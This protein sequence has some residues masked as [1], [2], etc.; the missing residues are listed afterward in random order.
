[1][2][3][4]LSTAEVQPDD[5]A[6]RLARRER[7]LAEMEAADV[8]ILVVGREANARYVAGAPR[9]WLAGT[10]PFGPGAVLV[11]QTGSV[12]LMNTWDEGVPDDI[13]HEHLFGITFNALNFI[14]ALRDVD[15]AATARTV[16]TDAMNGGA[17]RMLSQSFPD[18]DLVDGEQLLQRA[19]RTKLPMEIDEIRAAVAVAE[20]ALEA[21]EAA[22]APGVTEQQLTGRFM[23]AMAAQGV[24]IPSTQDVAWI[25]SRQHPWHRTRRD[26]PI[27]PDDLVA[28]EAGVIRDGYIG[29]FGRTRVAGEANARAAELFRRRDDLCERLIAA[30]RPGAPLTGLLDA[31]DAAGVAAPPMPVARGLGLGYDTPVVTHALRQTASA[32]VFEPGMVLVLAAY[33]WQAGV[34]A[35]YGQEPVVITEGRPELLSSTPIVDR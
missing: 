24:T 4:P 29:E 32:E 19:R 26:T 18:A 23:E 9:L 3:P 2:K 22:L 33:V 15:G 10:R 8:D 34:G 11:R 1:M 12:Y 5:A 7:V 13:P 16:A 31:Y 21:A 17:M 30:C 28:F 25:T 27:A 20:H 35:A 6:L 14:Q